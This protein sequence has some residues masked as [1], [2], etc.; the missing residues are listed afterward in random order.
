MKIILFN[1]ALGY[2]NYRQIIEFVL[3]NLKNEIVYRSEVLN[4]IH[5]FKF[6]FKTF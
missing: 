2:F 3:E 6:S 4:R 5:N 1:L